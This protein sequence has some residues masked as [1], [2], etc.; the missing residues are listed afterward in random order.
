[1]A[2]RRRPIDILEGLSVPVYRMAE[3]EF[4]EL[5]VDLELRNPQIEDQLRA[6]PEVAEQLE[7]VDRGKEFHAVVA[8]PAEPISADDLQKLIS[9]RQPFTLIESSLRGRFG[10][11]PLIGRPDAVHFDGLGGAWVVEHKVRERPYLTPSDDAQLRLYG[12]LL[13]QDKRFD[14]ERLA[15][16]CVITGREAAEK[17]MGFPENR[18]IGLAQAVCKEPPGPSEPRRRWDE[19][20]TRGLGTTRLRAATF[21]YD[22]EKARKELS[23]L[24]AYWLGTR[25]PIPTPRPTK[26]SVCRVNALRLCPVPRARF[27]EHG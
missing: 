3:Q 14:V 22:P 24:A 7:R 2:K 18:K 10:S 26:C 19:H 11:L 8:A 13:K 23:F 25:Q 21:H 12:F 1:M 16:V 27:R 6:L 17:I 5:K 4:C 9:S 15:L 20:S